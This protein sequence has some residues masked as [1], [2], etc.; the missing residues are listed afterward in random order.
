MFHKIIITLYLTRVMNVEVE[1]ESQN[2]KHSNQ[3]KLNQGVFKMNCQAWK[4][5]DLD[6]FAS[7]ISHQLLQHMS[8]KLDPLSSG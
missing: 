7:R 3:W 6:L 2:L 5:P 4:T 1:W 8:W